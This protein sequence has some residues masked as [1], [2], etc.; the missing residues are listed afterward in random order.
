[1]EISVC[2]I[3]RNEE[4][5]LLRALN[6]IP[7][8]YEKIVLDTGSTDNTVIIAKNAN[9]K[10]FHSEWKDDFSR[11][12]NESIA[13]ATGSHILILDAD[14]E[15]ASGVEEQIKLFVGQYPDQA[16][17]VLFHNIVRDETK[18]HRM[19]RFMPNSPMFSFRGVVHEKLYFQ[20]DE[21]D[22]QSTGIQILHYGY[23]QEQYQEKGKFERYAALYHKHL[24]QHPDDGYMLYQ[25]GKLH[26]SAGD[27]VSACNWLQQC[28]EFGEENRL[29]F[30]PMLVLFG[31]ALKNAGL[32]QLAEELLESY[33]HRFPSFPDIPFLLGLLAMESGNFQKIE[34]YYL[35][36][37]SIGDTEKYSS[38]LGIGTFKASFNLGIYYEITGD[39][40]KARHY[41]NYAA[42]F[43]YQPAQERL[44]YLE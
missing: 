32:V 36:A 34:Q 40:S 12:R 24:K 6:S 16:G 9:A 14:E 3:V 41:L 44:L 10:V 35:M 22:F 31:Y 26:Y 38:S 19:V 23:E 2:L 42:S 29:Y 11:A 20:N 5:T 27:Y 25:M 4:K 37:I 13:H 28:F 8:A 7:A 15:L 43:G 1:M 21:A 39:K 30:P 33:M 18:T 17:T